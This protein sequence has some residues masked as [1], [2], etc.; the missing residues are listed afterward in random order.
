MTKNVGKGLEQ[1]AGTVR[2]LQRD[3]ARMTNLRGRT[4]SIDGSSVDWLAVVV[5]DHDRPPDEFVPPANAGSLAAVVLLRRDWEFLFNQLKSTHAVMQYLWRIAGKPVALGREP[6]RYFELARA[7]AAARAQPIDT[8]VVATG[9]RPLSAP[10]LPVQPAGTAGMREHLLVRSLFEDIATSPIKHGEEEQR[11]IVL[12]ALDGL[13]VAH[14]AGVGRYVQD[15]LAQARKAK[16]PEVLWRLERIVAGDGALQLGFGAGSPE[17][18]DFYQGVFGSWV[19]LRHW[20]LQERVGASE[21]LTTVAVVLTP[22][23][24]AADDWDT[25]MSALKGRLD[26]TGQEVLDLQRIW[27][28]RT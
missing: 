3:P 15:A 5:V 13:Q 4:V 28:L 8:S 12:G 6:V 25:T 9:G 22:R 20:E 14:R 17:M 26:L 2:S 10:L 18:T 1:A 23:P 27:R 21:Q 7:D 19:Q 24:G 11:L 16:P